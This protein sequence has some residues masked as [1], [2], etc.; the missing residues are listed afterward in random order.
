MRLFLS[1]LFFGFVSAGMLLA[2]NIGDSI[3]AGSFWTMP[4]NEMINKYLVGVGY[5]KSGEKSM[6]LAASGALAIGDLQPREIEW[7]WDEAEEH[8]ESLLLILYSKGDD[9]VID[10]KDFTERVKN[11]QTALDALT[12]VSGRKKNVATSESGVKLKAWLW[13]WENGAAMLEAHDHGKKKDYEAEFIRL[14]FAPDVAGLERGGAAD[15]GSR[16]SLKDKVQRTAEGDVWIEGIPMVDQGEKGYCL[17]ATVARI[18]AHYG[19][20]GVDMH[21]LASLCDTGASGGT[22]LFS[23]LE[24]L[25]VIGRRFHVKTVE[26]VDKSKRP[27]LAAI[28]E[29]YNK[30]ARRKGSPEIA[31]FEG[32]PDRDVDKV[33]ERFDSELLE[34]SFPVKK[35]AMKKWFRDIYRHIDAGVPVL[36]A[37]PGHMRMIMGYNEKEGIIY[38]SDTW[39]AGHEKKKMTNLKAYMITQYRCILRL[40]K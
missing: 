12:G 39:G 15:A 26:L 16:R 34:A 22:Y 1:S 3:Q 18:F 37:I 6:R 38:Y 33:V 28:V 14:R 2:A 27:S 9:G 30:L 36:W 29:S 11:A 25:D 5:R 7:M 19:M 21:A 4:K 17:P 10:K 13:E 24:A 32:V 20:D 8:P 35:A 23:M 40:S 31:G